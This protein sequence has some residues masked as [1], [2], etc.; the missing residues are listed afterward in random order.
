[1]PVDL[2]RYR[3]RILRLSIGYP[4][5]EVGEFIDPLRSGP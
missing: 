2:R 1:M 5:N 3:G 4:L